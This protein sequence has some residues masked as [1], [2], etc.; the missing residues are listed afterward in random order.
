MPR[1]DRTTDAT[2]QAKKISA[3]QSGCVEQAAH[4]ADGRLEEAAR[5]AEAFAEERSAQAR[6]RI[7]KARQRAKR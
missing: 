1:S 7:A 3:E 5:R 4:R 2:E 6:R